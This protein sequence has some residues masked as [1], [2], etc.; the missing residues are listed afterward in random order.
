M[1]APDRDEFIPTRA[2]LL[3]RLKD[4]QDHSSWQDFFNIYWK[5][6]Y[7][8]A[9]K[10]GLNEVEAQDVVQETMASV[11]KHMPTFKYDPAI[12][13]FKAWLLT[14]TRWRIIGQFRKRG[15]FAEHRPLAG[16]T[17]TVADVAE[18]AVDPAGP[19]LEAVWD[20]EWENDLLDAAIAKVK[21]RLDPQKYQI[22]DF[23]VN[24]GWSPERVA[25]RFNVSV[26]QVYVIKH[27]VTEIIRAEVKRLEKEMV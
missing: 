23:Y 21:P 15:P 17:N 24:N 25:G 14:M 16:D 2:S 10:A 7:G 8:V 9:R 11:A 1:A 5:L 6:I 22:F 4:W 20:A 27:R 13:S 3:N 18:R 12:G 26:D 19:E